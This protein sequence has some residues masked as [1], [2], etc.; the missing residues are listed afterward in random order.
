[1][2][3]FAVD[4]SVL[5]AVLKEEPEAER[6]SQLLSTARWM[7]GW[8]SL[9][10]TRIWTLRNRNTGDLSWLNLIL[11]DDRVEK[12]AFNRD[13]ER[14]AG[15]AYRVFG[16]G[17]HP[18]QLNYGDCMAYAVA[19]HHELPLLFKGEDFSMTDVLIHPDSAAQA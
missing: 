19:K 9:L 14:L 17:F 8:P 5:V 11:T 6:F 12:V 16:K 2:S 15:G 13:L 18:A 4:T 10:E 3:A 1:M 7:I